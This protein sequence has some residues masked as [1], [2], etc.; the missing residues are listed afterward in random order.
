MQENKWNEPGWGEFCDAFG[1][2]PRN[3]IIEFF[4]E[5]RE[6]DFSTGD[7]ARETRLNRATAYNIMGELVKE[8]YVAP[9]RKVSGSQLYRLNAAKE[10]VKLLIKAFNLVLRITTEKYMKTYEDR[11]RRKVYA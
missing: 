9:T 8:K 5:G 2:T 10:E 11:K 1:A 4:L 3:R 7:V 6:L